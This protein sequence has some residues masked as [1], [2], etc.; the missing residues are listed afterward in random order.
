MSQLNLFQLGGVY[1]GE[2]VRMTPPR[3]PDVNAQR[4]AMKRLDFLIGDWTGTA[5]LLRAPGVV[6]ELD[7]TERA[8]YRLDGLVLLIEGVG[9]DRATAA[10]VLQA[11]G[12]VTYDDERGTY[13]MRA[14]ND[15]RFLETDVTLVETG[16]GLSWGFALGDVRTRSVLE[17]TGDGAWTERAE[18]T[19]GSA[20]PKTLLELSVRRTKSA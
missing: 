15:G 9:R 16:R 20:P 1:V 17:I 6:V 5:R 7:Q 10:S 14:F 3:V 2:L 4:G 12:V 8:E 11:L 13:R 18:L 19:I